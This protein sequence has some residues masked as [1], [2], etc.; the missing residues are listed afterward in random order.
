M[1]FREAEIAQVR[2]YIELGVR[3]VGLTGGLFTPAAMAGRDMD[4]IR[5]LAARAAQEVQ[6]AAG[7]PDPART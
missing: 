4:A 6:A 5:G 3:V 2:N 1:G 7:S